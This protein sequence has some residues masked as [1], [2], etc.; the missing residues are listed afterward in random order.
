M[1]FNVDEDQECPV[2]I[3]CRHAKLI[4]TATSKRINEIGEAHPSLAKQST[5]YLVEIPVVNASPIAPANIIVYKA[6]SIATT[7][8]S[9]AK[10]PQVNATA[11]I[12]KPESIPQAT[13]ACSTPSTSIP[14]HPPQDIQQ[15]H[16]TMIHNNKYLPQS[17]L[18]DSPI[19]PMDDGM[20]DDSMTPPSLH[21]D[22][23][24]L[25][26]DQDGFL[27]SVEDIQMQEAPIVRNREYYERQVLSVIDRGIAYLTANAKPDH[28]FR[29]NGQDVNAEILSRFRLHELYDE[30][31]MGLLIAT[32][33]HRDDWACVLPDI[34]FRR[35]SKNIKNVIYLARREHWLL[36]HVNFEVMELTHYTSDTHNAEEANAFVDDV[37]KTAQGK[38]KKKKTVKTTRFFGAERVVDFAMASDESGTLTWWQAEILL[39]LLEQ[40]RLQS[41]YETRLRHANQVVKELHTNFVPR[42]PANYT[43]T[44]PP[45]DS[46][47]PDDSGDF[48]DSFNSQDGAEN[49]CSVS[50][51]GCVA[52]SAS[53]SLNLEQEMPNGKPESEDDDDAEPPSGKPMPTDK[54]FRDSAKATADEVLELSNNEG[55]P[56]ETEFVAPRPSDD[57]IARLTTAQKRQ[58]LKTL[59]A[60]TLR[61]LIG[62]PPLGSTLREDLV[63]TILKMGVAMPDSIRWNF[64]LRSIYTGWS[65]EKVEDLDKTSLKLEC[66]RLDIAIG[67][68]STK[69]SLIALI[70]SFDKNNGIGHNVKVSSTEN[71]ELIELSKVV[72]ACRERGIAFNIRH[73]GNKQLINTLK[74]RITDYD[75]MEEERLKRVTDPRLGLFRIDPK[76]PVIIMSCARESGTLTA[77]KK[78]KYQ[79]EHDRVEHALRSGKILENLEKA[80][81][82]RFTFSGMSFRDR[83]PLGPRALYPN[84]AKGE[85][86]DTLKT[87]ERGS[88]IIFVAIGLD[89]ISGNVPGWREFVEVFQNRCRKALQMNLMIAESVEQWHAAQLLWS[90]LD[91]YGPFEERYWI[92]CNL[93]ELL[94]PASKVRLHRQIHLQWKRCGD[95]RETM[96]RGIQM[97]KRLVVGRSGGPRTKR[98]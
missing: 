92:C 57:E 66:R 2:A 36:V 52:D 98:S 68:P 37:H 93:D 60:W 42:R 89:G 51:D 5:L 29:L 19:F 61:T 85:L 56:C 34:E 33:G 58:A 14:T 20:L 73:C 62:M 18:N 7:N 8:S 9:I 83:L 88:Q 27:N 91:W 87:A 64:L 26:D 6:L 78:E 3:R 59:N 12:T 13:T 94:D 67:P 39:G 75:D 54:S 1:G 74:K 16:D 45:D 48:N 72:A 24:D 63:N 69:A 90:K 96:S 35:L 81:Y 22:Y 53:A 50:T 23:L 49:T 70:Q 40:D 86:V 32:C 10:S 25:Q 30:N 41:I 43:D 15:S 84:G 21:R 97:Q 79:R 77:E 4:L 47:D 55:D 31:I 82:K 11:V 95:G 80:T 76:R 65:R 28:L 44:M 17:L 46:D 38:K 71:P